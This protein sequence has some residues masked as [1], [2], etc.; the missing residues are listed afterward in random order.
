MHSPSFWQIDGHPLSVV[1]CGVLNLKKNKKRF[2][3]RFE[4]DR[5]FPKKFANPL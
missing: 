5:D 3:T 4:D 1:S 2:F